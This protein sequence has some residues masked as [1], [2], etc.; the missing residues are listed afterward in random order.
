MS[1]LR[2]WIL[3]ACAMVFLV[4]ATGCSSLDPT[5]GKIAAVLDGIDGN[6]PKARCTPM[7]GGMDRMNALHLC[8]DR[9]IKAIVP[10]EL[11]D[12]VLRVEQHTS[13][14]TIFFQPRVY[15]RLIE[16]ADMNRITVYVQI[17]DI[18]GSL[19]WSYAGYPYIGYRHNQGQTKSFLDYLGLLPYL[20]VITS[21]FVEA[22]EGTMG[23]TG[24]DE[25]D[26]ARRKYLPPRISEPIT[27]GNYMEVDIVPIEDW[28]AFKAIHFPED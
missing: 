10:Q 7:L 6:V 3:A 22:W 27:V 13:V 2:S 28:K 16:P 23:D 9:P 20:K 15:V 19:F 25:E 24:V 1:S 5:P 14:L 17:R 12:E 4:I 21:F 18:G 11:S 26:R 8:Y